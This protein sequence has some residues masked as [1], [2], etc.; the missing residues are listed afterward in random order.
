MA[1]EQVLKINAFCPKCCIEYCSLL[2]ECPECEVNREIQDD[3]EIITCMFCHERKQ[4][5][6][7]ILKRRLCAECNSKCDKIL[8]KKYFS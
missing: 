3:C 5:P 2:G 6:K 8:K 4:I 7:D 1:K